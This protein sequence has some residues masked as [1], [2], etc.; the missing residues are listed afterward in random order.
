MKKLI[1][2]DDHFLIT[3]GSGMV[4]SAIFRCLNKSIYGK[5]ENNG[6]LYAPT[7][8]ELNLLNYE[9]VHNWFSIYKPSVVI[10]AAGK[11][12]GI[13]ANSKFPA[14]FI[15]ENLK[16]QTNLID[17]SWKFNVKRLLFLG[18]SCIYPKYSKQPIKE[19]YLLKDN[20]EPTNEWYAI[21]K[22]AGIKLC[23]SLRMQYE[24]DAISLMPTNLYGPGD[25]YKLSESHVLPALI[26]KFNEAKILGDRSVSCWGSGEPLREFLHVDD[27]ASACLYVLENWDPSSSNCPV[28]SNNKPLLYLNVGSGNEISIKRLAEMIAKESGFP[29]QIDWDLSKPDGTPR[30][31]LDIG[32]I[33]SIGWE[34]SITIK[35]GI[36]RTIS[37]YKKELSEKTLRI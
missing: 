28:D 19:E 12:G 5:K 16:I 10:I 35:E 14:D 17:I 33:R 8:K 25:N 27:L 7:R 34:P 1:S 23:Q 21:A 6:K 18:S 31:L 24:F 13:E 30:K 20:L 4:G 37:T 11:V 2:K 9:E 36:K 29:G 26:R 15:L 32:K 3:G 22:I